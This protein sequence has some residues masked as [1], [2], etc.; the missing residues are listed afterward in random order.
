MN[1]SPIGIRTRRGGLL[2]GELAECAMRCVVLVRRLRTMNWRRRATTAGR[3]RWLEEGDAHLGR[4]EEVAASGCSLNFDCAPRR[5]SHFSRRPHALRIRPSSPPSRD[6]TGTA[7]AAEW[8]ALARD[9]DLVVAGA[10]STPTAMAGG[11]IL[12]YNARKV[13]YAQPLF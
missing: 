12:I 5:G 3:P 9:Q 4:R 1:A 10:A 13:S 7:G 2:Q 8:P 11:L 6:N